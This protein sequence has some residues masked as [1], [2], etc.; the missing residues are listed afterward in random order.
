M[1]VYKDE[2]SGKIV[3]MATPAEFERLKKA[4]NYY[5]SKLYYARNYYH[6]AKGVPKEKKAYVSTILQPVQ[7][8]QLSSSP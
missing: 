3:I 8:F 2:D 5:D 4:V 6:K 1:E 7:E